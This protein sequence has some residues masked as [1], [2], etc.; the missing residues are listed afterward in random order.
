[1]PVDCVKFDISLIRQLLDGNRQ[2]II[3]ES[4]AD[5]VIKADYEL[6]AEGIETEDMLEKI[7]LLGFTRAQG[8]LFGRPE[9][10][11]KKPA[12]TSFFEKKRDV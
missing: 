4:L 7:S 11:C 6:I 5:M 10:T 2:S 3:I 8:F 1:M 12:K 9:N